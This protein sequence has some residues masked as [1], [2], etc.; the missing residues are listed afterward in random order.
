VFSLKQ[1]GTSNVVNMKIVGANSASHAVGLDKQAG[2][3]NYFI[4]NDPSKWH[5]DI[6]NF[7]EVWYRGVYRGIDLVYHGNQKQLE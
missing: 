1:G 3:S 6:P 2:V 7:S 4:G 5:T